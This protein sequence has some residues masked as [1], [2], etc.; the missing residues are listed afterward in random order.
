VAQTVAQRKIEEV[1]E[2][3]QKISE[4]SFES[5]EEEEEEEPEKPK[6]EEKR[7]KIDEK[8]PKKKPVQAPKIEPLMPSAESPEE[9]V[10]IA[11][12]KGHLRITSYVHLTVILKL[13]CDQI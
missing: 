1:E 3:A 2:L 7:P 10:S 11:I 9:M 6:V 4:V 5:E 12:V 8:K 13:K